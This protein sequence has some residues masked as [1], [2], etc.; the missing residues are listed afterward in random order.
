MTASDYLNF[1]LTNNINIL[2]I[3]AGSKHP[4]YSWKQYKSARWEKSQD[5][6]IHN[7]NFFVVCGKISENLKVLDIE[8][9]DIYEKHFTDIESFTV[10]TPHGGVHIYYR[11]DDNLNRIS[12]INGWPAEIRGE[13]HGCASAGSQV[14][15]NV[16]EV[17]KDVSIISLDLSK[18][19]HERLIKLSDDRD[20]SVQS[21]KKQID[22]SKVISKTVEM[23]SEIKGGWMGICPFHNDKNPSLAVYKDCYYCFGCGEHGDVIDWVRKQD[24]IGFKEAVEKLSS[25]YGVEAPKFHGSNRTNAGRNSNGKEKSSFQNIMKNG[26]KCPYAKII[27]DGKGVPRVFPQIEAIAAHLIK[28]FDLLAICEEN[29][30]ENLALWIISENEYRQLT[31]SGDLFMIKEMQNVTTGYEF[32]GSDLSKYVDK[33]W[34]SRIEILRQAEVKH[35]VQPIKGMFPMANGIL[36]VK[37]KKL[38]KDDDDKICLVRSSVEYD[39]NA[40]C[41]EFDRFL[42]DIFDN[43]QNKIEAFL[44]WLGAVV[45]GLEPQI[46]IM[47][48]SRGRSG[49]GVL[50]TVVCNLLG[51]MITMKSPNDLHARFSNWAFLHRR[52]TYLE[53]FDGKMATINAMKE[54]SG[55]V[56]SVSFETKGV[57]AMMNAPVQCAIFLNTN[58]P[59]PFEK[60]SA[61][62]ERLKLLAFP[63]SY[64]ENPDPMKPWEKKIDY[65]IKERLMEELP[66]ILNRI[67]PYAQYALDHPGKMFKQD[68]PYKNI[69]ESLGKATDSLDS[70]INDCCELAPVGQDYY[71]NMKTKYGDF[72][73]TDTTFMKRYTEYCERP[74][75]NVRTPASKY[76]KK[77]LKQDYRVII[78][79]HNLRGIKVKEKTESTAK[80]NKDIF[81]FGAMAEGP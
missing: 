70:F 68:I 67:L 6:E 48:L 76:V 40:K 81:S 23:K 38:I 61:I 77:T 10:R 69:E 19:A 78:D 74:E 49:K 65:S 60:G 64:V 71:G 1:Y 53:E 42:A 55:G 35:I 3:D 11:H 15:G 54:L 30:E 9:W 26:E 58:N 12:S 5:L 34:I 13:G 56:P 59:P 20:T 63:N 17:I 73:V 79:G 80:T 41:P 47:L 25:E 24:G 36:D 2:P 66:G 14:D 31:S 7:G 46:I 27:K 43:D 75:I 52:A 4:A 57:Q 29:Q 44:S 32:D 37:N 62:E 16:Y 28:K 51:G 8:N 18:L 50:M 45:A 22:I 33:K 21:W 72:A 39:P